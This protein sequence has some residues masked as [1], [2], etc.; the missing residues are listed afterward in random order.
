MHLA[1]LAENALFGSSLKMKKI[2]NCTILNPKGNSYCRRKNSARGPRFKVEELLTE[3]D[4]LIQSH[5]QVQ[6]EANVALPHFTRQLAV[7]V[8]Q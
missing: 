7:A 4:M 5:I 8:C 3:I 2:E 1:S 6:T